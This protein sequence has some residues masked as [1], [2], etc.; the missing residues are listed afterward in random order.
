MGSNRDPLDLIE[1]Q[2]VFAAVV[3]FGRLG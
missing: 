1:R 2:L 3:E